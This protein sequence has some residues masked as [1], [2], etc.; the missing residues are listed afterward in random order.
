MPRSA[1]TTSAEPDATCMP[2]LESN[3]GNV[4]HAARI[5]YGLGS[6]LL[7]NEGMEEQVIIT[8]MHY[9][10]AFSVQWTPMSLELRIARNL[11]STH[12]Q[13]QKCSVEQADLQWCAFCILPIWCLP[14]CGQL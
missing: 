2:S 9:C 12:S 14:A 6:I 3:A 1:C 11:C 4:S 13:R 10:Y 5:P 7:R 8:V